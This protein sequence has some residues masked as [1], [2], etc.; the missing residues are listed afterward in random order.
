MIIYKLPDKKDWNQIFHR[1]YENTSQIIKVVEEVLENIKNSGDKAVSYYNR[2][3]DNYFLTN[4]Q[5]SEKLIAEV[6]SRIGSELKTAIKTAADNISKFHQ[7][8][9]QE[10][11]KVETMPGVTCWQK[12]VPVEKVGLYIPGGTAPLFSTVLMLAIPASIAGCKEIILC[13]PPDGEGNIADEILYAAQITGVDK[14][15]KIGGAQ[16]IGAMAYG[17]E[18]IPK[19]DKIFGPGNQYVTV[20]KQLVSLQG[21]S[22]DMPAGPSEVLIIS[23]DSTAPEFIAADLLSQ[24]EH[25]SDSQVILLTKDEGFL[26]SVLISLEEQLDSLPRK[27]IA[28]ECLKSSIAVIANSDKEMAE[29]S[30]FYAPEHLIISTKNYSKIVQD[31]NNAGSV[32]LGKYTPESAGDYASGTNHTLPTGGFARSMSGVNLDAF[33]KKITYQEITGPGLK[34]IGSTIEIMSKAEG[35]MAHKNAVS[36]RLRKMEN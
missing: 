15:Y 14:I 35:L 1:P 18:T 8:Q 16:A 2:K 25:G 12:S 34:N 13:T 3:F 6:E 32:F 26:N 19:A 21:T 5:V 22:I 29:I 4:N 30:N 36:V 9:K 23:D 20:A 24:A 7:A 10:A 33:I 11:V 28:A 31:I 27:K 17:T